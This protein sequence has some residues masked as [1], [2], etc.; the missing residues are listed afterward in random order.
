MV[1]FDTLN[2]SSLPDV[3]GLF[4][5]GGFPEASMQA[6]EENAGMRREIKDFIDSDGPAYVECGGLMYLCR[7]ITWGQESRQMVDVIPAD[8]VMHQSPQGRGYV[9]L[10][11]TSR[12]PWGYMAEA[13]IHAHEFHYSGLSGLEQEGLG[14]DFA[15]QVDR[16]F[17]VDGQHDGIVYKNLLANYSHM[18]NTE[19]NP[20]VPHFVDFVRR[21]KGK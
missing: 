2:D 21:N 16:G 18:R 6:L 5:G 12:H 17:G 15:Y 20:W 19:M 4:L 11:E 1:P 14:L 3:D 8:I 7:Q 9:L 10:S 13:Q